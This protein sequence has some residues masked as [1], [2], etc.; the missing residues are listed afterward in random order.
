M[1]YKGE[2]RLGNE[3]MRYL[4]KGKWLKLRELGVSNY[5]VISV[6]MILRWMVI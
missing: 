6:I 5:M 2:C 3:G 1:S 4:V